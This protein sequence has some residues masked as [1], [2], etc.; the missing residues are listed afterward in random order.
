MTL[1][2]FVSNVC[3]QKHF[4]GFAILIDKETKYVHYCSTLQVYGDRSIY[5]VHL[6]HITQSHLC[7]RSVLPLQ[8]S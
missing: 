8:S 2:G 4:E 7:I 6:P 1:S 3:F 5:S